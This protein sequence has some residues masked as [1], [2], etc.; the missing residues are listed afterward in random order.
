[1]VRV[2]TSSIGVVSGVLPIN[3]LLRAVAVLIGVN[4]AVVLKGDGHCGHRRGKKITHFV[5]TFGAY[6]LIPTHCMTE[7]PSVTVTIQQNIYA[8]ML[9]T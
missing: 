2:Y 9:V 1:M 3:L 8:H 7:D 5:L 4:H 6:F